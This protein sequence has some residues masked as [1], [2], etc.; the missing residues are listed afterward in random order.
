LFEE[1]KSDPESQSNI[2][3]VCCQN[4]ATKSKA[5]M[6]KKGRYKVVKKFDRLYLCFRT[7]KQSKK[8]PLINTYSTTGAKSIY[9]S[10][11][12]SL[13]EPQTKR[14]EINSSTFKRRENLTQTELAE[15]VDSL[16]TIKGLRQVISRIYLES[17]CKY[18]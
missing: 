15:K 16:R 17:S 3:A 10:V 8:L 1:H 14:N 13:Q 2:I 4:I 9:N 12:E 18:L 5:Q 7:I 6:T 11:A